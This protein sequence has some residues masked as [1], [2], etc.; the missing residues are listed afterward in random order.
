MNSLFYN[1]L[2]SIQTDFVTCRSPLYFLRQ[3]WPPLRPCF[4]VKHYSPSSPT[5]ACAALL[6]YSGS[7]CFSRMS[8]CPIY[9]YQPKLKHPPRLAFVLERMHVQTLSS[10]V[11]STT[12][13]RTLIS[14]KPVP[15]HP[16]TIGLLAHLPDRTASRAT[17]TSEEA[18]SRDESLRTSA[19]FEKL[20]LLRAAQD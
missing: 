2:R 16:P 14:S 3:T 15:Q 11:P 5:S 18:Q 4:C 6:C 12:P 19:A 8:F 13:L 7:L 10:C 9:A 20:F 17:V 1:C